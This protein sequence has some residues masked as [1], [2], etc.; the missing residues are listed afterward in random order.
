[1][2]HSRF[3]IQDLGIL[4][5][6]LG[7]EVAYSKNGIFLNQRK[8]VLDLLKATGKMGVKPCDTPTEIG[9]KLNNDGDVLSDIGSYQSM[10]AKLGLAQTLVVSAPDVEL[11]VVVLGITLGEEIDV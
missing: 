7:L 9:N 6:F 4:K 1:M 10:E 8:Y 5:Y 11:S 2:L 3:D